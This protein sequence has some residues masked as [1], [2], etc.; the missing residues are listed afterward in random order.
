MDFREILDR[1]DAR[2]GRSV[3]DTVEDDF[4]Q[5]APG[6]PPDALSDGLAAAFRADE[7]PEFARALST[8]GRT[9]RGTAGRTARR[10]R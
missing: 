5:V 4:D 2:D 6:V 9:R 10:P 3:P 8:S 1:Y 7:T